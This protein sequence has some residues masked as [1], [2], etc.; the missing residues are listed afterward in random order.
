MI[1]ASSVVKRQKEQLCHG[2]C[3]GEGFFFKDSAMLYMLA[4][5]FPQLSSFDLDRG[6][7][8]KKRGVG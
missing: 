7:R 1:A 4:I 6:M 5:L 8:G 2:V 3:Y